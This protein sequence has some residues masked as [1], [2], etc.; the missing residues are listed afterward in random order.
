MNTTKKT[1]SPKKLA[2]LAGARA[3][4]AAKRQKDLA[5]Q[6][7]IRKATTRPRVTA[8]TTIAPQPIVPII[9]APKPQPAPSINMEYVNTKPVSAKKLAQLAEA[10]AVLA[11][12]RARRKRIDAEYEAKR[13]AER[14]IDALASASRAP[15]D[16][17]RVGEKFTFDEMVEGRLPGEYPYY[18]QRH[19]K[20]RTAA[21]LIRSD[22]DVQRYL[23]DLNTQDIRATGKFRAL[24]AVD[25][26]QHLRGTTA[27]D[28]DASETPELPK[29]HNLDEEDLEE[30]DP[31]G[32]QPYRGEDKYDK[33]V[34]DYYYSPA[35]AEGGSTCAGGSGGGCGRAGKSVAENCLL[36]IMNLMNMK[37]GKVYEKF[38]HLRPNNTGETIYITH[39]EI[40][41]VSRLLRCNITVYTALGW[42]IG[43]PWHEFTYNT[44]R[45]INIIIEN[46][47]AYLVR[48]HFDLEDIVY[49]AL[50]DIREI[51]GLV[52]DHEYY[53]V[54][55][56]PAHIQEKYPDVTLIPKYYTVLHEGKYHMLKD[57]KVSTFTGN[58]RD[59]EGLKHAYIFNDSQYLFKVF[60]KKHDLR[61]VMQEDMRNIIKAAEH[62]SG[63]EIFAKV[64]PQLRV[65]DHNKSFVAYKTCPYYMGFPG[66][67]FAASAT[68][69]PAG[70]TYV[71]TFVACKDI[72]GLPMHAARVLRYTRGPIVLPTPLYKYLLTI[73]Q[74]IDVDYYVASTVS[75]IDIVAYAEAANIDEMEKKAF[76]NSLIGRCIAGGL[77]ETKCRLIQCG[78]ERERAQI[79]YECQ[80]NNISVT[81][82]GPD[83]MSLKVAYKSHTKGLYQ[84]H[85]YILAYAAVQLISK[86]G[87]IA[88]APGCTLAGYN[89]DSVFYYGDYD[90]SERAT[91]IGGWKYER[92]ADKTLLKHLKVSKMED[93]P[94]RE[95]PRPKHLEGFRYTKNTLILGPPGVGKSHEFR[96]S[97]LFDQVLT[98]PTRRL[99]ER[100]KEGPYGFEN[101]L[102]T[103]KYIQFGMEADALK[104]MRKCGRL[105]RLHGTHVVDEFTMFDE[106]QWNMIYERSGGKRMIVLGDDKQICNSINAPAITVEWFE[107][108][109]FDIKYV[110]R[111][112]EK[113]CRQS[114]DEGCVLDALRSEIETY[115]TDMQ[116]KERR[117]LEVAAH[118]RQVELLR[119][120]VG[121]EVDDVLACFPQMIDG[122]HFDIYVSDRHKKL[123]IVNTAARKYCQDNGLLFPVNNGKGVI[124]RVSPDD[125]LIWWGRTCMKDVK[126]SELRYEPAVAVTADSIQ[127][128]DIS[129]KIYV[130]VRMVRD[131]C[132]YTTVTRPF[133]LSQIIYVR[134]EPT[135]EVASPE[136]PKGVPTPTEIAM[137][138]YPDECMPD[139]D[140]DAFVADIAAGCDVEPVVA[141]RS[142][143][144][145]PTKYSKLNEVPNEGFI[146]HTEW[147]YR[148]FLQFDDYAHF[149]SWSNEQP[150][151]ERCYHEVV[152]NDVR[153]IVVDI[154]G[155]GIPKE[156]W[157]DTARKFITSFVDTFR[158][159]FSTYLWTDDI[160]VVD[161][162]GYSVTGGADKFSLQIRTANYMV[163]RATCAHF[164]AAYVDRLGELGGYVDTGVYK[165]IQ[166][167]RCVGSTKLGDN[168]HSRM[169]P[170]GQDPEYSL[171]NTCPY[172]TVLEPLVSAKET[173]SVI[174]SD[175]H[176]L[177]I[178]EAA[179]PYTEGLTYK[180]R[181]GLHTFV[182]T[183]M[184]HCNICSRS[185][186]ADGMLVNCDDQGNVI[187]KCWRDIYDKDSRGSKGVVLFT[188]DPPEVTVSPPT[189]PS[190]PSEPPIEAVEVGP[191][192]DGPMI[193]HPKKL[194]RKWTTKGQMKLAKL[195]VKYIFETWPKKEAGELPTTFVEY[196]CY[197]RLE[198]IGKRVVA[199]MERDPKYENGREVKK[200]VKAAFEKR[201][202]EI[203]QINA[204]A[205]RSS[206]VNL[207]VLV[208]LQKMAKKY[209][210]AKDY[211]RALVYHSRWAYDLAL[212]AC[213]EVDALDSGVIRSVTHAIDLWASIN[214][215]MP[216]TAPSTPLFPLDI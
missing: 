146:I 17:K 54:G 104:A 24:R 59:H 38:P 88:N 166:N 199:A 145:P 126:P 8:K 47:H 68:P 105:P 200:I 107:A 213:E 186:E 169:V 208:D 193:D 174:I 44:N 130:D 75:D 152:H 149:T 92:A 30:R 203:S 33:L 81:M 135:L 15:V 198:A 143:C 184:S 132:F 129:Q 138:L 192:E 1:P 55:T 133:T 45:K 31:Y 180:L 19:T 165:N 112:P 131:R 7:A 43:K 64:T 178:I 110:A 94:L 82:D 204:A 62:F 34:A 22:T 148:H 20:P 195:K 144:K 73:C 36:N 123:N 5:D 97:P 96:E 187:L 14:A 155:K 209:C 108:R 102:T 176:A 83:N 183:R 154:D 77:K 116:W 39:D 48:Q 28:Y 6:E 84:F 71:D 171:V 106:A 181:R 119:P 12:N 153:K 214:P 78:S 37:V 109:G 162:S 121:G 211:Y 100:H 99:R 93:F 95:V 147:P 18:I 76:R 16:R 179:A 164:A 115:P 117:D 172:P 136:W 90:G 87:E 141:M 60:K 127:G 10:R 80:T 159:L 140:V 4:K 188:F 41:E 86:M 158:E 23:R 50:P 9:P 142:A 210:R 125:P 157:K 58:P 32:L 72:V 185:H 42:R 70:S 191:L 2:Q 182:R 51:E 61:T 216:T 202:A 170:A 120:Y 29:Y 163:N 175:E 40:E 137:E 66:N 189:P 25:S 26:E 160:V 46:E 118:K 207:R 53:N 56:A 196:A 139:A 57:Y 201:H 197:E 122:D 111:T 65:L 49:G 101:T 150:E 85:S 89:V 91:E 168:R 128:S 212:A 177:R 173:I 3:A 194:H 21:T 69:Q 35:N 161:A 113:K 27:R 190:N 124:I 13:A 134:A 205:P 156:A 151:A 103:A 98:T 67:E 114:Y 79:L 63:R 52:V 167:F 215:V 206:P 11:K 74:G